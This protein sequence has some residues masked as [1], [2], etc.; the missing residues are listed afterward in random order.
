MRCKVKVTGGTAGLRLDLRTKVA[1]AGTSLL[2]A[3]KTIGADGTCS[4]PVA[5]P[6][7]E[8][9][10]AAAVLLAP[11]GTVIHK[12]NTTVGGGEP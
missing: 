5:D 1:D 8:G 3:P 11:D 10:L 9:T 12:Q 4:V 7:K 2:E 6:D